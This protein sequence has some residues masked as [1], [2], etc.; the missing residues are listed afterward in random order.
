MAFLQSVDPEG[1]PPA[2][3]ALTLTMGGWPD[4]SD[5]F[6]AARKEFLRRA[7][8]LGVPLHHWVVE[9]TTL[10]RPHLHLALYGECAS[11]ETRWMLVCQWLLICDSRGWPA[12]AAAQTAE[13]ITSVIGWLQYVSKHGARG[14]THYQRSTPPSGWEKTGRLWGKSGNW[15]CPEPLQ[16]DLTEAEYHRFRRLA[17]GLARSRLRAAGLSSTKVRRVGSQLRSPD[18]YASRVA[19]IGYWLDRDAADALV[20]ESLGRQPVI[21]YDQPWEQEPT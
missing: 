2:G 16:Y 7:R 3:I 6:H 12:G 18:E 15:P 13:P 19:G 20:T 11:A 8:R 4:S 21:H 10:G 17:I 5:D 14:V 1:L 9:S